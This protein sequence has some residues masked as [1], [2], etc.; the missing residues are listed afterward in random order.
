[1]TKILCPDGVVRDIAEVKNS[2]F[3]N[4]PRVVLAALLA[5]QKPRKKKRSHS[6]RLKW[7]N[8]GVDFK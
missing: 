8:K 4:Y 5:G 6:Q 3:E 1:M 7:L 2:E